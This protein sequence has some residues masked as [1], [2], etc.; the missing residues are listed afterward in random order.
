V[1]RA[2]LFDLDG[3]LIDSGTD[4]ALA[5]QHALRSLGISP[6]PSPEEV[7]PLL[8][9]PLERMTAI[10]G[11]HLTPVAVENLIEAYRAHYMEHCFDNTTIYQGV[12]DTLKALRPRDL[13]I[14]TTKRQD[15]AEYV[16]SMSGLTKY[17]RR[18]QGW[19][20]GL[21]HKP[22]PDLIRKALSELLVSPSET[23]MV[24]DT[25]QDILAGQAAGVQTCF[26]TYGYGNASFV[27]R[28]RPDFMIAAPLDLLDVPGI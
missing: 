15:Q 23:L 19:E 12:E 27:K 1:I 11:Y 24:G 9:K 25:E 8:G 2:I 21:Q 28:L 4:I 3:T 26:A 6:V 13:G 7:Y 22:A 10:L 16:V 17:F 14:V 5:F 18:V 20:K